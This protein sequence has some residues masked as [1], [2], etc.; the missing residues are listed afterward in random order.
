M[1]A[2]RLLGLT[3]VSSWLLVGCSSSKKIEV[4]GT[5]IL[6]SDCNSSLLCTD[7]KCHDAC[8]ASIDCPTGQNCVKT[9]NTTICQLPAEADCSRTTCSS[10]YVCASDLRCRTVCQSAVDCADAQV[11]VTNVCA[12]HNEL[13]KNTGQL[14]QK[15]PSLA[16]DG[17]TD[18]QATATGG[19]GGGGGPGGASGSSGG[20]GDAAA[21]GN[22]DSGA[23]DAAV[24]GSGGLIGTDGGVRGSGGASG[25]VGSGGQNLDASPDLRAD[26]P[27]SSGGTGGASGSDA[28]RDTTVVDAPVDRPADAAVPPD[29]PVTRSDD[30]GG[31]TVASGCGVV[32]TQRY[33]CDDFES[34]LDNWYHGSDGWGLTDTTYQSATHA[35]TDSPIGSYAKYSKSEITMAGFADLTGATAPVVTFWHKLA[36]ANMNSATPSG[37]DMAST[38][39]CGFSYS[40]NAYVEVSTD[41]GTNWTTL[42]NYTCAN[43]TSAWSFQQLSL[44]SYVAKRVML[45]FRLVDSDTHFE[46]DGW[47]LD[48]IE[49]READLAPSNSPDGGST[50]FVGVESTGCDGT[51]VGTRFFCDDFESGVSKWMV[52]TNGWNT[53]VGTAQSPTHAMTDSPDLNYALGA[54]TEITMVSSIDLTAAVWPVLTFWHKLALANMN[55]ATPSGS[56][57]ASSTYC[58]SSYSDNVY[59]DI[60]TDSGTTWTKLKNYTCASNTSTWSFQQ[61]SLAFYTG[62]KIKLRFRLE[63]TDTH[64]LG[65]GW[66]VDDVKIRDQVEFARPSNTAVP[67]TTA[68]FHFDGTNGST[69]L[70]DI[71]GT[72]KLPA[73][74]GNPVI[75][76][77]QSRFGGASLFING[78]ASSHTNYVYIPDSGD[79]GLTFEGDFTIDFWMYPVA[80]TDSF[81]DVF[82]SLPS[83]DYGCYLSGATVCV[84]ICIRPSSWCSFT[85]DVPVPALGAWQHV[86]I[87]R[88]GSTVRYFLNGVLAWTYA[89]STKIGGGILLSDDVSLSDN[90]DFN[91]YFDELRVVKGTAV[92]TDNFIPPT[93]P[94]PDK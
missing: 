89:N 11:C 3:M 22:K 87:T 92:W 23:G 6:N 64:Y 39:Y 84:T 52:A 48:D 62:T 37:S 9:N 94:Y 13:D 8:H 90:G 45:R 58:G 75:S 44:L 66:Y 38:T 32:T 77:V 74:T 69:D 65:D 81:S 78:N 55:S 10:T 76:T 7:R 93:A 83:R 79:G 19:A 85:A 33:F 20:A 24:P 71:S 15:G 86:A 70:T 88:S 5:C 14:P 25:A 4:G 36:L 18:A 91:G 46:G 80:F 57:M 43:N 54:K 30:G 31:S 53:E 63:D 42:K 72:G 26:V 35:V 73:I 67:G 34:G 49:I 21:A 59:V 28:A 2:K 56:D 61:L 40:D 1:S 50:Q 51:V 16:A 12:D 17:G 41:G 82:S 47:S 68:L 60:S 27:G 29:A